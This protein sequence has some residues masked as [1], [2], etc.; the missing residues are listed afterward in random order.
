M[1]S[2]L[3]VEVSL[4]PAMLMSL[5]PEVRKRSSPEVISDPRFVVVSEVLV[6]DFFLDPPLETVLSRRIEVVMLMSPFVASR[7]VDPALVILDP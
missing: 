5:A 7:R 4:D 3:L 6:Q 1:I 2:V